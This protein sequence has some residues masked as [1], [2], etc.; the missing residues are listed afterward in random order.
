MKCG[1]CRVSMIL[2]VLGILLSAQAAADSVNLESE[3]EP[4]LEEYRL[5]AL[6]A[7]VVK[8]GRIVSS[9]AVGK[10][11]FDADIPVTIHDRFH[12][13]SATKAMTALLAGIMVEEGK[14]DWD[15][16]IADAFPELADNMDP[17][18]GEVT[19]V[20]L[21]SHTSGMQPDNKEFINLIK[22]SYH[23]ETANLDQLRYWLV[24]QWCKKPLAA[25]PGEK[26]AYSNMGYTLAGAMIEQVNDKTWDELI[27]ERI[28]K[29]LDLQSAGLGCQA[30]LGTVDAPLGH[31]LREG[32]PRAHLPGPNCDNPPILGPA[33]IAHMSILDFARWAG[34]NAGNGTREPFLVRSKTLEKLHTPVI[35]LPKTENPPWGVSSSKSYAALDWGVLEVDWAPHTMRFHVGSNGMNLAYIW[36][37]IKADIAMVIVTN[38][39]GEKAEQ[40]LF[41]LSSELYPDREGQ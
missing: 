27:T 34:W 29:P 24:Q 19:L 11:K 3:L 36:L 23:L 1:P 10:R 12:I 8:E 41:K 15:S 5:P 6:A 33:G 31:S 26:F 9:G 35:G 21:L 20:Q 17:G 4:Y 30:S 13:G 7:A 38:I 37:D 39:A 25:E 22:K 2:M 28:F 14:L 40:A 16:S 18:V 32:K